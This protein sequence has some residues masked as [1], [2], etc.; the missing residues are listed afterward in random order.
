MVEEKMAHLK[1]GIIHYLFIFVC[2]IPF[3]QAEETPDWENPKIFGIN[4]EMAHN[5]LMVYPDIPSAI[6]NSRSSSP[7]FQS[8]NGLWKFHWVNKPAD[9]PREFY[10][11]DFNVEHWENIPV[12]SN[13]QMEGY[14]IPIYL[15]HPYPFKKNPPFIQHEYNPVGSYRTEFEIPETWDNRQVFLH[16]DGV[17]SAFYLWINGQKVGYSQ[18]SRT[19]AEFNVTQYLKPGKNILAAE[20]YRWSDGSYLECQDFWRLSGI[21]RDVYVF[22]APFVH[23]RDFEVITDLDENYTHSNLKVITKITN[24]SLSPQNVQIEVSVRNNKELPIGRNPF[25][26]DSIETIPPEEEKIISIETNIQNPAKWSAESPTLYTLLLVLKDTDGNIL[27][28]E[29]CRFGFREVEMK[30]GQLLVNSKPVLLKGVNRHEHDPITGHYVTKESMIQDIKLM[31]QFNLNAV[32]TSHYPDTPLWYDLCDEYGIYLIDEANIESHGMGYRPDT[33]LGNNPEWKE[34]HLDRIKRMVERDKNHPSV[35][36]WSMGNE[37]GDG[38]NFEVCS[39]W[40]HERDSQRPVHYERAGR[41]AHVDIVS[42]MYMRIEGLVKYAGQPQD[43]PLILCEYAHAMGNSVGNLQDYWDVIEREPQLQ[44]GFIWDWVDQALARTTSDGRP[45]FAY[46]GDFGDNFNDGNF[47]CN[48]LVQPDRTPNPHYYEVKKVYSYVSV[49]PIDL[50]AG[51]VSI[52]NKYDF[53]PLDFL[54]I[55]WEM[56]EDGK[57]IQKDTLPKMNLSPKQSQ[58]IRIPFKKPKLKP[59]SE[60]LIKV[61]FKLAEDTLWAKKGYLLAWDQFKLPFKT[62]PAPKPNI[63]DMPDLA[64]EESTAAYQVTG[65]SFQLTID[66]D[67]GSIESFK[68]QGKELVSRPLAPNFWRAPIDNDN[69]NRMPERQSV[70]RTAG[71]GRVVSNIDV[72]QPNPKKVRIQVDCLLPAGKSDLSI[73]YTIYGSG[74]VVVESSFKPGMELPNLPRVGMQMGIP[75]EFNTITWY[76]RGP[77]ESYWDRKTGAAVGLYSGSVEEQIHPYIRPQ[78]VGNKTDVRWVT[79]TNQDGAGLRIVGQP[80]LSVSAWPFSMSDLEQAEHTFDL[81]FRSLVTLNID[82]K[83]MGVGGDNSW[84]AR[85]HPEYTLPAKPYKYSFR[86]SP[87]SGSQNTARKFCRLYEGRTV[88]Q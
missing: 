6:K 9:R 27:E 33:T 63:Q 32:R 34:A 59:G 77:H 80:L 51:I 22:S 69:G 61:M 18:G 58:D 82:F 67:S 23:I 25:I 2:L 35:I 74:D 11:P 29:S 16:F 60:Y 55:S 20:V 4:K 24:Y 31:K 84:G 76:G 56:T 14:G 30:N 8:L 19:P 40:I 52:R 87:I 17:E 10:K 70:W 47:L 72:Q 85:P 38:V 54:D 50:S 78:E 46:G 1:K 62:P 43:R 12:P 73:I 88:H 3:L 15:N 64:V 75:G 28:V 26:K 57:V 7:F 36:I 65:D 5:T 42:P 68:F 71:P 48:G 81:N 41:R 37:A 21:F 39:A 79:L 83:Q 86:I 66:K 44:G 13:W 53:V 49:E 45:F